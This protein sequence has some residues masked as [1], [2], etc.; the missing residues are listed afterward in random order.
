M[1]LLGVYWGEQ[2]K[3][4]SQPPLYPLPLGDLP[5]T[6]CPFP[7]EQASKTQSRLKIHGL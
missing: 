5:V 1:V 6:D 3:A 4:L 7:S 2:G